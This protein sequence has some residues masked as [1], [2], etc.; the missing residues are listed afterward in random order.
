ML[1]ELKRLERDFSDMRRIMQ[2]VSISELQ[3]EEAAQYAVFFSGVETFGAAWKIQ[4]AHRV[5][6][7]KLYERQGHTDAKNWLAQVT[8][9]S[10]GAAEA[11]LRTAR[12]LD[13]HPEIRD[14]FTSGEISEQRAAQV[15]SAVKADPDSQKELLDAAKTV[16]F[17]D[18][19]DQCQKARERADSGVSEAERHEKIRLNRF[20]RTW[21][22]SEGAGRIEAR[23]TKDALALLEAAIAPH[24]KAVFEEQRKDGTRDPEAAQMADA[25]VSMAR[26]S[27]PPGDFKGKVPRLL[28]RISCDLGAIE[29]GYSDTEATCRIPGIDGLVPVGAVKDALLGSDA[30][31]QLVIKKGTDVRAVVTDTRYIS[32]AL[33][34]AIEERDKRCVVPG[35]QN[36]KYLEIDH[37]QKDFS[38]DG[39]TC[40]DNLCLMCSKHHDMKSSGRWRTKDGPG[41]WKWEP[42]GK[43][44]PPHRRSPVT[45]QT[46]VC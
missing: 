38:K 20:F 29:N 26:S 27:V 30:L 34:A 31:V 28:V 14:A 46:L 23:V 11:E 2:S 9:E 37:W 44:A 16:D 21:V 13:A 25:L 12:A 15:A 5:E 19:S 18:L 24:K 6:E 42:T 41:S 3:G 10:V 45:Q 33:R 1:D 8:G 32:P 35:C 36:S 22:D 4:A 39:P 40:Y 7:T 43:Q 17:K